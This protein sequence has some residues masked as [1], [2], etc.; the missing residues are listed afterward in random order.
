MHKPYRLAQS[1][2]KIFPEKIAY[3]REPVCTFRR[4]DL[5]PAVTVRLRVPCTVLCDGKQPYLRIEFAF[6]FLPH[7]NHTVRSA[8]VHVGLA[9]AQPHLSDEDILNLH[10]YLSFCGKHYVLRFGCCRRRLDLYFPH[11]IESCLHSHRVIP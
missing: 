11:C 9:A 5:P 4:T 8:V 7:I 10:P 2:G 1:L 3:G 6:Q